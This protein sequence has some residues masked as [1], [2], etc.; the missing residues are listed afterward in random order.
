[1]GAVRRRAGRRRGEGEGAPRRGDP[2]RC[3]PHG[4]LQRVDVRGGGRASRGRAPVAAA[5][6][7][8][9]ARGPQRRHRTSLD[10]P[11][12]PPRHIPRVA[13]RRGGGGRGRPRAGGAAGRRGAVRARRGRAVARRARGRRHAAR[14]HGRHGA[15]R[16][17]DRRVRAVVRPAPRTRR[18]GGRR[19]RDPRADADFRR[20]AVRSRRRGDAT[21]RRGRGRRP[22]RQGRQDAAPRRRRGRARGGGRATPGDGCRRRSRRRGGADSVRRGGRARGRSPAWTVSSPRVPTRSAWRATRCARRPSTRRSSAACAPRASRWT[23]APRRARRHS[24]G[25]RRS[26]R[27]SA[28]GG[29]SRKAPIAPRATARASTW[30]CRWMRR[31]G[32]GTRRSPRWRGSGVSW[33]RTRRGSRAFGR[34]RR[35]ST[36]C[37][38]CWPRRRSR[39]RQRRARR[40]STLAGPGPLQAMKRNTNA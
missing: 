40:P 10:G 24:C 19:G 27:S 18:V 35:G 30:V 7:G 34:S 3:A 11:C 13:R 39:T 36:R 26:A 12:R 8:P 21:A 9:P 5:R 38:C 33:T 1:V 32:R 15:R 25:P 28:C 14:R 23:C 6:R 2:S 29:S 4:R 17:G 16:R 20:G 31:S 37:A 22:C